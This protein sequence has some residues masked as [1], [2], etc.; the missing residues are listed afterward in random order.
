MLAEGLN[1]EKEAIL[2]YFI[3]NEGDIEKRQIFLNERSKNIGHLKQKKEGI[4]SI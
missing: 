3:Y 4:G 1:I 2:P